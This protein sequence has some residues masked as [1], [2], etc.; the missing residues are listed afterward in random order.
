MSYPRSNR[1][2]IL[3]WVPSFRQIFALGLF[4]VVLGVGA[5]AYAVKTTDIPQPNE[6]SQAQTTIFYYDDAKTELGRLG[7]ANRVSVPID[8]IPLATQRTVLSAE[9]R[10]FYQHGG[11]SIK[12]I[13]RA[14]VNNVKHSS[15]QGGSTITQQ[16][17]KNAY[18]SDERR[19][20]RKAKELVLSIKL[21]TQTSKDK[22]L[23]DYLN[24]IYF[25]RGAYGIE[26]AA[27]QYFGKSVQDLSV[28]QSAVLAAIIQ[29]PNGLSPETNLDGLKSRWNYVLDGMVSQSWLVAG[30]RASM[31]FPKIK[32]E[33]PNEVFGGWK[34]YLLEQARQAAYDQGITEDQINRAGLRIVTTFNKQAQ[35]AA[36]KAIKEEGPKTGADGLRIGIAA[37]RPGTGE[38]V[39]IYGGKD[40]L[41]NQVNNATQAIGQ[42]GSTF[43]PFTLA[44]ALEN[45]LSLSTSFSGKNHTKVDNYDVVNYSNHSYGK[46]ITLLKA[47]EESVNSAFVQCAKRVGL[48]TVMESAIRAGIPRDAVGMEPNLAFTLGTASPHVIDVASAYSTFAARGLQVS[49]SYIKLITDSNGKEIYKLSPR[50][51]QAFA[52]KISDTVSYAMQKVVQVGTGTPAKALGRPAAGK[53]GTT[54][55]NMSAWFAGFTPELSTA[56]MLVKD[57]PD[58][59]PMT[60][61]GTGGMQTVYGASFPAHIWTAFMKY[62][63]E[64]TPISELPK[65]PKGQPSGAH[66]TDSPSPKPSASL[67]ASPTASGSPKPSATQSASATP[68]VSP[69]PK[70]ITAPDLSSPAFLGSLSVP[71]SFLEAVGVAQQMNILLVASNTPNDINTGNWYIDAGSQNKAAGTLIPKGTII[72][73][74]VTNTP[75]S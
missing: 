4:L 42:A 8:E 23:E 2:G 74:R 53:T 32:K 10:T 15:T 57:G 59:Q 47:T 46:R 75:P 24:T 16:Y 19:F 18:L 48:E 67:T 70:M 26:T 36:V 73:V 22:I 66:P 40:Y 21:E 38:V 56:V 6:V 5:L 69:S 34:G 45:K 63:L 64:G 50:P 55:D 68:T 39:A 29:A 7:E 60:L 54:N 44:A 14:V 33:S 12:G 37:V 72:T 58:G 65:L 20:K 35:L 30:E 9:D 51:I 13:A 31:K 28:E 11:F 1:T 27:N 52:T 62:A 25:G 43:K 49:P 3:R 71:G 41:K 61:R 17:A